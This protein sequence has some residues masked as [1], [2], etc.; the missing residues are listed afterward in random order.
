MTA[1]PSG[2][3]ESAWRWGARITAGYLFGGFIVGMG[4]GFV[5]GAPFIPLP[6]SVKVVIAGAAAL[7]AMVFASVR[8]AASIGQRLGVEDG[9]RLR[10][11]G[12][13]SFGPAAILT[14]LVLTLLEPRALGAH[15]FPIHVVYGLLFVPASFAAATLT[16]SVICVGLRVRVREAWRIALT[17]GAAAA[18]AFLIVYLGMDAAGWSVGGPHAARRATMLVV[19]ALGSLSAA[20]AGGAALGA[21]LARGASTRRSTP[22][23]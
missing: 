20:I 22:E 6:Q 21:A 9:H 4:A 8:W 17:T 5:L 15:A 1:Q 19:T 7:G 13:L 11:A 10:W 2:N 12:A 23:E 18:L 14:G 3:V 16:I